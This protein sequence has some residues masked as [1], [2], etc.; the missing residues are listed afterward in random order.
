NPSSS[1]NC[2]TTVLASR[3][4][5]QISIDAGCV[6]SRGLAMMGHPTLLNPLTTRAPL[7]QEATCSAPDVLWP[8]NSP[9]FKRSGPRRMG[10]VASIS[11]LLVKSP[12][13]RRASWVLVHGVDRRTTAASAAAS[14]TDVTR[15]LGPADRKSS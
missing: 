9:S 12:A 1:D 4:S 11:T 15:A 10:L 7:A 14:L 8:T 6:P 3:S 13:E 5:P 2:F